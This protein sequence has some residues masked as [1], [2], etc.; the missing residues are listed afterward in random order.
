M[1][2]FIQGEYHPINKSKYIGDRKPIFR[3]S[4]EHTVMV[5]FDQNPNIISWASEPLRIPYRNPFTG[6]QTVYVPDFLV[7]Y[8]DASG[9]QITELIEVKP[10]KETNIEEAKS[11]QAKAALALNTYKWAAA[12]AFARQHGIGFRVMTEYNIYNNPKRKS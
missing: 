2:R 1:A 10:S 12:H 11:K 5:M 8:V 6:K 3:S 7:T 9:K 4:W